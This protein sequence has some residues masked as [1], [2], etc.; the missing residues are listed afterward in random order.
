MSDYVEV[1]GMKYPTRR[2]V[3]GRKG[4]GSIDL[5]FSIVTIALS[6]YRPFPAV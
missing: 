5:D 4:D 6:D 3:Y 1:D 2:S